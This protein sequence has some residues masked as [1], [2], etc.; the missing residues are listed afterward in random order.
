VEYVFYNPAEDFVAEVG[1]PIR[2]KSQN[3]DLNQ[4]R[5]Y[6]KDFKTYV[7]S[8][9]VGFRKIT[10]PVIVTKSQPAYVLRTLEQWYIKT[11]MFRAYSETQV[12]VEY[13]SGYGSAGIPSRYATYYY[14]SGNTWKS[15]IE[16]LNLF[17]QAPDDNIIGKL[18]A[19]F[20]KGNVGPQWIDAETWKMSFVNLRPESDDEINI[21]KTDIGTLDYGDYFSDDSRNVDYLN[22]SFLTKSQLA[23]V[24]N[25][26]YARLSYKFKS[27][28]LAEFFKKNLFEYKPMYTNVDSSIGK[29]QRKIIELIR[30]EES[31]R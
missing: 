7:N 27:E 23:L 9:E 28:Y 4:D 12:T 6:I 29:N 14:G 1:F 10:N 11:V 16:A 20:L 24:R 30:D 13:T 19:P 17:V 25:G 22:F 8:A 15:G 2:I 26:F 5:D 21:S 18:E 3:V 31:R